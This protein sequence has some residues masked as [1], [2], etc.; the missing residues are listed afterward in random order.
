MPFLTS[1]TRRFHSASGRTSTAYTSTTHNCS[2][3]AVVLFVFALRLGTGPIGTGAVRFCGASDA[4]AP[5][6]RRPVGHGERQR[7]RHEPAWQG[8]LVGWPGPLE[9]EMTSNFPKPSEKFLKNLP[10]RKQ[11]CLRKICL[12]SGKSPGKGLAAAGPRRARGRAR[13]RGRVYRCS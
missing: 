8:G 2:D 7:R 1:C 5:P 13:R 11:I 10:G 9:A 6:A 12:P 3:V 4:A